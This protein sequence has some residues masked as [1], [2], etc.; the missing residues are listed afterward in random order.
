MPNEPTPP[1]T[2]L[3]GGTPAPQPS[4]TQ[5]Q[6]AAQLLKIRPASAPAQ[7][8]AA[9]NTGSHTAVNAAAQAR[10]VEA[11]NPSM[12]TLKKQI[13]R[14]NL[15]PKTTSRLALDIGTQIQEYTIEWVL[16]VGGFGITYL[17]LDSNLETEVAIK[18]YMPADMAMRHA[19][20]TLGAKEEGMAE[21]FKVGLDKFLAECRTLANFKHKNVVRVTR[22]FPANG[23]AYM[24][25]DYETGKTFREWLDNKGDIPE[26]ELVNMIV[27]LLDGLEVVHK[28]GFLHRDIK[29]ANLFVR[30]DDS[31]VLL[32]FGAARHAIGNVSKSLTTIVTPGYAPFEQYHSHGK[33]GPWTDLYA[34]GGVLYWVITG[35][36]PAEA[37][38]RIKH[39]S[40]QRA[41]AL[42]KGR[43]SEAFL[44]AIDWALIPDDTKRPQTVAQFRDAL[45]RALDPASAPASAPGSAPAS[46]PASSAPSPV[47][48]PVPPQQG[49][50]TVPQGPSRMSSPEDHAQATATKGQWWKFWKG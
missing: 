1:P 11:A 3:P 19:D 48:A 34:L 26:A 15:P 12:G 33:Q 28:A 36:K 29:P 21:A 44:A 46:A 43:Y 38:S 5:L 9:V 27:P 8:P 7:P 18:E 37:P 47:S 22:F 35:K 40:M 16:G 14:K 17:A 6:Q 25:M 45:K 2:P 50:S 49:P 32:D 23:T 42:G 20:G 24:V 41:T 30:D 31:M 10:K 39:D 4:V 13:D